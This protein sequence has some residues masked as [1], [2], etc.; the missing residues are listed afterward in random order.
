VKLSFEELFAGEV[1]Q[2]SLINE[3]IGEVDEARLRRESGRSAAGSGGI[4]SETIAAVREGEP[5]GPM[6]E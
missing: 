6:P 2:T 4:L 5:P 1:N 3:P